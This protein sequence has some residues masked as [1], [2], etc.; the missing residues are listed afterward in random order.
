M[1]T[2]VLLNALVPRVDK[3]HRA[4]RIEN[5]S[6]DGL[7]RDREEEERDRRRRERKK[8]RKERSKKRKRE[9][10]VEGRRGCEAGGARRPRGRDLLFVVVG[11][12]GAHSFHAGK[13]PY[14]GLAWL[15]FITRSK[16]DTLTLRAPVYLRP[17]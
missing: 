17:S 5:S 7:G 12:G 15:G 9:K 11:K 3:G 10:S 4:R 13:R 1:G 2:I 16:T 14:L 8:S 6:Q